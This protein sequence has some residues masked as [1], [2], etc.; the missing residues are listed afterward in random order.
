MRYAN[1]AYLKAALDKVQKE[2]ISVEKIVNELQELKAKGLLKDPQEE[3]YMSQLRTKWMED[4]AEEFRTA[5]FVDPGETKR[6]HEYFKDLEDAYSAEHTKEDE[7]ENL[8]AWISQREKVPEQ[9]KDIDLG[10]DHVYP[11]PVQLF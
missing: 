10:G 1:P 8:L 6:E 7:L 3:S 4:E 5:K 9:Y 11:L 2:V